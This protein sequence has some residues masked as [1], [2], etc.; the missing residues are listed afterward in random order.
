MSAKHTLVLTL[1]VT[2]LSLISFASENISTYQRFVDDGGG[3]SRYLL[4]LGNPQGDTARDT[5]ATTG[6]LDFPKYRGDDA[7]WF[8]INN[9][10]INSPPMNTK[11]VGDSAGDEFFGYML[12]R[13]ATIESLVLQDYS[14]AD[15]GRFTDTPTVEVLIG[16]RS[17]TWTPASAS[18]D[19]PYETNLIDGASSSY[20]ITL[21]TPAENVWGIRLIGEAHPTPDDPGGYVACRELQLIGS[22]DWG[23]I[24]LAFPVHMDEDDAEEEWIHRQHGGLEDARSTIDGDIENAA[25]FGRAQTTWSGS[26]IPAPHWCAVHWDTPKDDVAAVGWV[27]RMFNDGGWFVK[28]TIDIEYSQDG[29]DTWF[30]V[31]DLDTSSYDDMIDDL[32]AFRTSHPG[33]DAYNFDT[34]FLFTFDP[35]SD[36]TSIRIIG[37]PGGDAGF[38]GQGFIS[39]TE[40][41]VFQ[42]NP[43]PPPLA[44]VLTLPED[45]AILTDLRPTFI[46]QDAQP[47]APGTTIVS[48]DIRIDD[49][50]IH[51]IT[52]TNYVPAGDLTPGD[53]E[54]RVR[55]RDSNDTLSPFSPVRS[56]V[57]IDTT[58][59]PDLTTY[60]QFG[61]NGVI[62]RYLV[63]LGREYGE[64]ARSTTETTGIYDF[65]KVR[66]NAASWWTMNNGKTDTGVAV[67]FFRDDDHPIDEEFFGYKFKR[68]ATITHAELWDYSFVDGGPFQ[69]SPPEVQVLI[70]GRAGTWQTV[71]ATWS[72]EYNDT[73]IAGDEREYTITLDT[74]ALDVWGIRLFGEGWP[75]D[76]DP[77]GFVATREFKIHGDVEWN[78]V[79][80]SRNLARDATPVMSHVNGDATA[81]VDNNFGAASYVTTQGGPS[82]EPH[83]L[84]VTWDTPHQDIMA[85]GWVLR[86]RGDGGWIDP[87]DMAI[88]YTTDG[89]ISWSAVDN[90][91][92]GSY[93]HDLPAL[94]NIRTNSGAHL[95]TGFLF[96]FDPVPSADGI[97]LIGTPGGSAAFLSAI[98]FEVFPLIPEPGMLIGG[99]ALAFAALRRFFS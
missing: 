93:A 19:M 86:F 54:W 22:V 6:L 95:D 92:I 66:G 49:F 83:W 29:G 67:T 69:T 78:E 53:Y 42:R 47:Q 7:R 99:L 57:I 32:V 55:A 87:I 35:V 43:P 73:M 1:S 46:W 21:D 80:L 8:H 25:S 9:G 79:D 16:G 44:P 15:G 11:R 45:N 59:N 96:L 14:Y 65:P 94:I 48:Y 3:I 91:D 5:D 50:T 30:P 68:P 58:F 2:F 97:R 71:A 62:S 84:G 39:A 23:D 81:L 98:E 17:G 34:G 33:G 40:M 31:D 20:T 90:L 61:M 27:M 63:N 76:A 64:T 51:G 52:G 72:P 36:I 24:S 13:P 18:W 26:E 89:G 4:L 41:Q 74:P 28:N 85:A 88:E 38:E 10:D 77:T 75:F 37:D 60:H 56:F 12:K 70:G 82:E